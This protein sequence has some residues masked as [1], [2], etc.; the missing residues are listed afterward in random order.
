MNWLRNPY[1]LCQWVE[2]NVLLPIGLKPVEERRLRY[3]T[4]HWA[5]DK[6]GEVDRVLFLDV[7]TYYYQ[8]VMPLTRGYFFFRMSRF[9]Q[10]VLPNIDLIPVEKGPFNNVRI[11]DS[12]TVNE[13]NQIG[14]PMEYFGHIR[15]GLNTRYDPDGDNHSLARY[16]RWMGEL[17]EFAEELQDPTTIFLCS[18]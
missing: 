11:K 6:G 13:G 8:M 17:L 10:F 1:G 3:V 18:N 2:D 5:Y 16:K 9:I 15:F 14:I 7:V 4:N 12:L